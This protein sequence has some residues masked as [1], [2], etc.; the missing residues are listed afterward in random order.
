[1]YVR[2]YNQS[3]VCAFMFWDTGGQERYS[4]LSSQYYHDTDG[5]VL[6]FDIGKRETFDSLPEW[7]RLH[8]EYSDHDISGLVLGNKCDSIMRQV[9]AEEARN[10][11]EAQGF[12]YLETNAFDL[13]L[14]QT[15]FWA[16]MKKLVEARQICH[17]REE[18]VPA[19]RGYCYC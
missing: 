4:P 5:L 2:Y 1:M 18:L 13:H 10:W 17:H 7:L 8:S 15:A 19:E 14:V 6:V 11:A 3:D 9:S 12:V 16:L